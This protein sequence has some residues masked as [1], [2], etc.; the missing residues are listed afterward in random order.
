LQNGP[1]AD[2][3]YESLAT[4]QNEPYMLQVLHHNFTE[5]EQPID[6]KWGVIGS[7]SATLL[8][9]N[10]GFQRKQKYIHLVNEECCEKC[11]LSNE[12]AFRKL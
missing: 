8:G 11:T 6:W 7:G 1:R 12:C 4:N 10:C 9:I 5:R 2:C 3:N